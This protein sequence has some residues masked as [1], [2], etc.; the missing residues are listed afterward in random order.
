MPTATPTRPIVRTST[1]L[2]PTFTK[3]STTAAHAVMRWWPVID[4]TADAVSS[5]IPT[6]MA[7]SNTISTTPPGANAAPT[8][9]LSASRPKTYIATVSI[10]HGAMANFVQFTKM[11]RILVS[12]AFPFSCAASGPSRFVNCFASRYAFSATF[13]ATA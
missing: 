6:V 9:K 5:A 4:R 12:S 7:V 10:M 2:S 8:Q 11:K 13:K 1:T 3:T